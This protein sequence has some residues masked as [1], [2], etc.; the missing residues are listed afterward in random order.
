MANAGVQAQ[1]WGNKRPS[2][3][4]FRKLALGC[5]PFLL[6]IAAALLISLPAIRSDYIDDLDSAHHIMDGYFFRDAMRDLPVRHPVEYAITYYK[7]YPALGFVFWPPLYPFVEGVFF[8]LGGMNLT[9]AR[10]CLFSFTALLAVLGYML[11]RRGGLA[12]GYSVGAAML[13]L[14]TPSIT[15][16]SQMIMLEVPVLAMALLALFAYQRAVEGRNVTWPKLLALVTACV[17]AV[18]TKQPIAFLLPVL[19]LDIAVNHR[20]MVRD[21]RVWIAA[22]A[23]VVLLLPLAAFTLTVGSVGM[24][25]AF[26]NDK[27]VVYG[28][29]PPDRWTLE[30]WTYYFRLLPGL[31]NPVVLVLGIA[32]LVYGFF[33]RSFLRANLVWFGW[34]GCWWLMFSWFLNK[35]PRY[36]ALWIP[37]WV[38]LAVAFTFEVAKRKN[39]RLPA[40]VVL[41][42]AL[43][44]GMNSARSIKPRGF[45]GMDRIVT[46][47]LNGEPKGNIVYFGDYR[48]LFVPYVRMLDSSRKV[49]VLQGDKAL[50]EVPDIAALCRDYKAGFVFSEADAGAIP[51]AVANRLDGD[52]VFRRVMETSIDT[53][54]SPV[55]IIIYAYTGPMAASM[56]SI[57]LR[58]RIVDQTVTNKLRQ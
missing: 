7:Q 42:I 10:L 27:S 14:L 48:Q 17:A 16:L 39:F 47:V 13:I 22:A 20:E 43:L 44:I 52:Q 24:T 55:R 30:A 32:S 29:R 36:A 37:G 2:Q 35:Q 34:V 23:L 56:R 33:H 18:Y 21:R 25:Q 38:M 12:R 58:S 5:W 41:G 9:A 8:L 50:S 11:A 31:L 1:Q 51:L 57:P 28:F 19:G 3:V 4:W 15:R 45:R 40:Y 49:H 54:K 26:G 6:L 46:A 53:G